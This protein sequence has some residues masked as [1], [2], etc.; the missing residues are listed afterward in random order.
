MQPTKALELELVLQALPMQLAVLDQGGTIVF[1]NAAW[2][3]FARENGAADLAETSVGRNYLAVCDQ[4]EGEWSA[5]TCAK[6]SRPLPRS[7]KQLG[8][9]RSWPPRRSL[10]TIALVSQAAAPSSCVRW[11]LPAQLLR[12]HYLH[13]MGSCRIGQD[14]QT[15]VVNEHDESHEVRGLFVTDASTFPTATGVNPMLTIM[16]IAQRQHNTLKQWCR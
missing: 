4:S 10:S 5:P 9:K 3:T 12:L 6:G 14:A 16:S 1:V 8:S 2:Q 11:T 7:W 15:S 13:Q